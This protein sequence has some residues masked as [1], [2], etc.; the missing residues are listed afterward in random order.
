MEH[1][2]TMVEDLCECWEKENYT[3][4]G[5]CAAIH[6]H[7][8]P[9]FPEKGNSRVYRLKLRSVRY[10]RYSRKCW[11]CEGLSQSKGPIQGQPSLSS[12]L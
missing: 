2:K 7:S 8:E 5:R 1:V 6:Q 10:Y 11:K 3:D 9:S 4:T 12:G